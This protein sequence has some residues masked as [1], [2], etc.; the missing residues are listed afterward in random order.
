MKMHCQRS[1]MKA[2]VLHIGQPKTGTSA[3]QRFCGRNADKLE[4]EP[5]ALE[6]RASIQ[7]L[8]KDALSL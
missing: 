5:S 1:D 3:I 7:T 4:Q 6:R 8:H 2:L